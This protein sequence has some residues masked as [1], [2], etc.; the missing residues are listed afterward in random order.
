[1]KGGTPGTEIPLANR[2]GLL[3]TLILVD[4]GHFIFARLL[5]PHIH[6]ASSAFFVLAIATLEVGI[7]GWIR[8]ELR[9]SVY[10]K[11][12]GFFL[13][14]GLLV[15]G[16]TFLSFGSVAYLDPGTASLLGKSATLFGLGF[17]LF[18]LKDKLN[19][20]QKIGAAAALL[21]VFIISFQRAELLILGS[22]M[23]LT[24]SFFY[25]FHTALT[26]RY[27]E[28]I[29]FLNFYFFRL[30]STS[31]FLALYPLLSP[32][33]VWPDG[34]TWAL[35]LLA[36]TV[37]VAFSRWLYYVA[38][39]RLSMSLHA[40]VLTVSPIAAVLWALLIFGTLPTVQQF[41][42]GVAIL[43]GVYLATIQAKPSNKIPASG[44]GP[45]G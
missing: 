14:I 38:L 2:L 21:G 33:F 16:A 20:K 27:G 41:I 18:W 26:K 15:A 3:I 7:V 31:L 6:P 10:R 5:L 35:L 11:N 1:V 42:G 19:R 12:L 28:Q 36:G 44:L 43:V 32:S 8:G 39:R 17:G 40:I 22:L 25:T 9:L 29:D 23:V 37:N 30:L 45:D 24:S 13:L 4:S 34:E